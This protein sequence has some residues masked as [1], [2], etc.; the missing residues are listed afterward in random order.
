[1]THSTPTV[2][3][4]D[5]LLLIFLCFCLVNII[6]INRKINM[7]YRNNINCKFCFVQLSN[8]LTLFLSILKCN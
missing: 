3:K 7:K 6:A 1:M 2:Q 5:I 8:S 4:L